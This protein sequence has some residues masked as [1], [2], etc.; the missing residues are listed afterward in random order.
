VCSIW[1][2]LFVAMAEGKL[3]MVSLDGFGLWS[4]HNDMIDNMTEVVCDSL[5]GALVMGGSVGTKGSM[6]MMTTMVAASASC[7]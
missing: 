7:G 5:M 4:R 3:Y 6:M 2:M 1:G